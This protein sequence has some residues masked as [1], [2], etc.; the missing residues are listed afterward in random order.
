VVYPTHKRV[1]LPLF[2]CTELFQKSNISPIS[3]KVLPKKGRGQEAENIFF[4]LSNQGFKA[5]KFI[6]E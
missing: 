2:K 6:Y 3:F 1:I 5:P 4:A